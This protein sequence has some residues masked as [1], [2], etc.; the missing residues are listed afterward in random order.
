MGR[1]CAGLACWPT[2][3][4]SAGP[5]PRGALARPAAMLGGGGPTRRAAAT[6]AVKSSVMLGV[7][8]AQEAILGVKLFALHPRQGVVVEGKHAQLGIQHLF[9]EFAVTMIKLTEFR[10]SLHHRVHFV[11]WLLFKHC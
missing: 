5:L 6:T 9:V 1:C 11:L 8:H 3:D 2:I 7:V 4:C 10:V